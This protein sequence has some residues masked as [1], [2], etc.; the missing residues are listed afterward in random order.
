M[1]GE[2]SAFDPGPRTF[3]ATAVTPVRAVRL[4]RD[5]LMAWMRDHREV[6]ERLMR[7][8]AR[9]LRRTDH[10]LSDLVFTDVAGR[11][12]R[13]LL[14][15]AQQF[16]EQDGE[17][18]RVSHGLTQEELAQLV[19]ATRETVNKAL[20]DFVARGWITL[21]GRKSVA[22]I[23]LQRLATRARDAGLGVDSNADAVQRAA[24]DIADRF[25]IDEGQALALLHKLSDSS[26]RSLVH[27]ASEVV[28]DGPSAESLAHQL[29]GDPSAED[30]LASGLN[31]RNAC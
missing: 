14:R 19:G 22:I 16:G 25:A 28:K 2:L 30:R 21:D 24:G 7:I 13:L 26:G 20:G 9:R 6:A 11:V 29:V 27:V 3:T 15:L 10:D 12:A 4:Q 18:I 17:V 8:L 31:V 23:D 5:V 1:F